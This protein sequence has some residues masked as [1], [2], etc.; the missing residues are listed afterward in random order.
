M[1]RELNDLYDRE[2]YSGYG[3]NIKYDLN[4]LYEF[5]SIVD[6]DDLDDNNID[7]VKIKD[8]DKSYYDYIEPIS[9]I[10]GGCGLIALISYLIFK[11]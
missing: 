10:S 4:K 9:N 7:K 11:R 5:D 1:D 3:K 6:I 8:K 2:K